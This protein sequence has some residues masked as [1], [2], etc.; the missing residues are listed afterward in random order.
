[1]SKTDRPTD[2]QQRGV[3]WILTHNNPDDKFVSSAQIEEFASEDYDGPEIEVAADLYEP[4]QL[5]WEFD[6][7]DE[8]GESGT[9]HHQFWVNTKKQVRFSAVKKVFPKCHIEKA[10]D[11]NKVK[12]YCKKVA[13][14]QKT[15]QT[16]SDSQD[17]KYTTKM[18][19]EDLARIWPDFKDTSEDEMECFDSATRCLIDSD[20]PCWMLA[21]QP[22]VRKA[23]Q[24]YGTR[25][26]AQYARK[27]ED[28][29]I[30]ETPGPQQSDSELHQAEP[31]ECSSE[32][33]EES[34]QEGDGE[35]SDEDTEDSGETSS[36]CSE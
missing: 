20:I 9:H 13:T 32:G 34:D 2:T 8:V 11:I 23:F 29:N 7:Q 1:M 33:S 26:M 30:Y 17:D 4:W 6:G 5:G 31:S 18:F 36:E 12:S 14:R 27:D 21:V 16:N 3:Y 10:N 15:S 25:I 24:L 35:G 22:Q 28:K 19:W